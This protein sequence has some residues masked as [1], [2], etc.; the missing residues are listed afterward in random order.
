MRNCSS[1]KML[2]MVACICFES[3]GGTNAAEGA[4]DTTVAALVDRIRTVAP[5]EA[6]LPGLVAPNVFYGSEPGRRERAMKA[7]GS[8]G[9]W[10][11]APSTR[12]R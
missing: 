5:T 10:S 6:P 12:A 8:S 9:L 2:R 4:G 11:T 1:R 7:K 3:G